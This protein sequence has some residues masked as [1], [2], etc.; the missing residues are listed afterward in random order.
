MLGSCDCSRA[1]L[2]AS[3]LMRDCSGERETASSSA[4]SLWI[5]EVQRLSLSELAQACHRGN[6]A[7]S[8][9]RSED[10]AIPRAIANCSCISGSIITRRC[11]WSSP[12]PAVSRVLARIAQASR[13]LTHA[14]F[15]GLATDAIRRDQASVE[16]LRIIF[17]C[18]KSLAA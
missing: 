8:Q 1:A 10:L 4:N 11:V 12:A 7:D 14:G 18:S 3:A 5:A 16:K 9:L 2:K 15:S 6:C 13:A 17:F